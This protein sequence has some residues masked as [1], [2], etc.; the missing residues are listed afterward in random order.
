MKWFRL[1]KYFH[2]VKLMEE[3][4]S[5]AANYLELSCCKLL[6]LNAAECL[7]F[8][9]A[10]NARYF[11]ITQN[12]L[13]LFQLQSESSSIFFLRIVSSKNIV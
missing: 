2:A 10:I 13:F 11:Y 1:M 5:S 3:E 7:F 6:Y 12:L 4:I 8:S 9:H